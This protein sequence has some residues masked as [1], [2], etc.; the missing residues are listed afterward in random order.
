MVPEWLSIVAAA[1]GGGAFTELVRR[2]IPHKEKVLEMQLK[3]EH[4]AL[5]AQFKREAETDKTA[6]DLRAALWAEIERLNKRVVELEAK[7]EH[8]S[9]IAVTLRAENIVLK[10]ELELVSKRV[11]IEFKDNPKL[12][13]QI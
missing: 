12:E 3:R 5:E 1:L 7:L 13:G 9:Q 8:T 11:G 2:I 4:D 10:A 6:A